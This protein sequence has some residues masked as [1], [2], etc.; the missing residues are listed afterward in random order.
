[1][2]RSEDALTRERRRAAVR[3]IS[4]L[5][6]YL[7]EPEQLGKDAG[8]EA[9]ETLLEKIG[10]VLDSAEDR[11]LLEAAIH[12]YNE[13]TGATLF[14]PTYV[15][16]LQRPHLPVVRLRTRLT[17]KSSAPVRQAAHYPPAPQAARDSPARQVR[18]K[19]CDVNC[20]CNSDFI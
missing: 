20:T 16:P 7:P 13:A 12:S 5:S 1:M 3:Q 2:G 10:P 15:Q 4:T 19:G 8:V 18:I 17:S 9:V 14:A 11:A 6:K